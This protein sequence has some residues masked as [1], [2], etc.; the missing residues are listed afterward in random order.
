LASRMTIGG[1][2]VTQG[3]LITS[4]T[5]TMGDP[6]RLMVDGLNTEEGISVPKGFNVRPPQK[7]DL[8][9]TPR[10][11]KKRKERLPKTERTSATHTNRLRL[12]R[13]ERRRQRRKTQ[14]WLSL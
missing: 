11:K 13:Y 9:H 2:E 1:D 5:F 4:P 6:G 12:Q 10:K 8:L 7:K 3:A 14:V